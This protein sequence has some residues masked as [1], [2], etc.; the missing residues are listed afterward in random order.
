MKP[1][2]LT[3][4]D[5]FIAFFMINRVRYYSFT[6]EELDFIPSI[7]SGQASVTTSSIA[8][9]G[10]VERK[11]RKKAITYYYDMKGGKI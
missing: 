8:W 11:I 4:S 1:K 5:L 3:N 7:Y 9:G 6:D 10:I 2:L